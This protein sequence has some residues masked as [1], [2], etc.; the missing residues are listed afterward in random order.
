MKVA[1]IEFATRGVIGVVDDEGAETIRACFGAEAAESANDDEVPSLLRL[2]WPAQRE[3]TSWMEQAP[4]VIEGA[5]SGARFVAQQ[6]AVLL[7]CSRLLVDIGTALGAEVFDVADQHT[8]VIS[9]NGVTPA[10][11][12]PASDEPLI[13][14]YLE[15]IKPVLGRVKRSGR[16]RVVRDTP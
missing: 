15:A 9:S 2:E 3:Q 12:E 14:R 10:T 11:P 4:A 6:F 16:Q 5:A 13:G 1:V 7:G 8:A